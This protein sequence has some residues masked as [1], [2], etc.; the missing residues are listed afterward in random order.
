MSN[1]KELTQ[2]NSNSNHGEKILERKGNRWL[3]VF[4]DSMLY[5][6]CWLVFFILHPSMKQMLPAATNAVYLLLGYS[7]FFGLSFAF[8]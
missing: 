7:L 4:Y 8:M 6:L 3:L 2:N 1:H 5:L